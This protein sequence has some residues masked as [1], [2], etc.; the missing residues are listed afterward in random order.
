MNVFYFFFQAEDGIRDGRVTGVQTCALPIYTLGDIIKLLKR[1]GD[2]DPAIGKTLEGLWGYTS[3]APGVRHGG[4]VAPTITEREARWV[5]D[6]SQAAL[7]FL[8]ELDR[9]T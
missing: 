3:N 1:R 7:Q 2:L 5:V 8:L 6:M 4:T 9:P